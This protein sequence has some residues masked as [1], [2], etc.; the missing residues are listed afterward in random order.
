MGRSRAA[1]VLLLPLLVFVGCSGDEDAATTTTVAGDT[2]TAVTSDPDG[3]GAATT[4]AGTAGTASAADAAAAAETTTTID[5]TAATIPEYSIQ[6]R[7]VGETGDTVVVFVEPATYTDLDIES[8]VTDVVSRFAP[9]TTVHVIDDR[10]V[11]D[12]VLSEESALSP[13]QVATRDAHYFARLE[14]GFRLVF[15]GPF[16]SVPES[17]LGS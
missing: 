5:P 3:D 13:E 15:K 4:T 7:I 8:V 16:E 14:E 9:I 6:A 11:V 12:L 10:E 2:T 1:V 17:I